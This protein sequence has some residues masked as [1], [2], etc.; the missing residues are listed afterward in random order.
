MIHLASIGITLIVLV[1]A[2]DSFGED[3]VA[4]A[5]KSLTSVKLTAIA[6]EKFDRTQPD[7]SQIA[8]KI[9]KAGAQVVLVV[10]SSAAVVDAIKAL[11]VASRHRR[12]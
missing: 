8:P 10:A 3:G 11:R 7:F 5:Q 6:I 1:H 2:D 4:G 9:T 12:W